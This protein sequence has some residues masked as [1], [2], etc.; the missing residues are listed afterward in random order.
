[1][2][3]RLLYLGS[4]FLLFLVLAFFSYTLEKE[5]LIT[6]ETG[7]MTR[8]L[9]HLEEQLKNNQAHY[10]TKII[11]DTQEY[12]LS[13]Y[14][15]DHLPI[16]T[17]HSSAP[18]WN[19]VTWLDK[20]TLYVHHEPS[21]YFLGV[22]SMVVSKKIETFPIIIR[23][24]ALFVPL[25]L[26]MALI[27]LVLSRI[28]FKPARNAFESVDTFIKHATHDLNTPIAAIL[29]NTRILEEKITEPSLHRFVRRITIG[30]KT[31]T[32]LY[33][34]LA[35][36][37]FQPHAP[38]PKPESIKELLQE[39]LS[40]LENLI[41]YKQL[42]VTTDLSDIKL[43]VHA[44]DFHRLLNNLLTNAIKYTAPKGLILL[45]MSLEYFSI[46]DSGI[47]LSEAE[48]QKIHER[49]WRGESFEAGLGIG[50]E[51]VVRVCKTYNL[52]LEIHSAKNQGS[53]FIIRWPKSLIA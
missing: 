31:L 10:L 48:K 33:E 6:D 41:E 39:Q 4:L 46:K 40:L 13:L 27:G 35:Y 12:R 16:A 5:R 37:N 52:T 38:I 30:A 53:E 45:T 14:D 36:L 47:G 15:I 50:M 32:G 49:Y 23:L 42:S 8:Y 20:S 28:A 19:D 2:Q 51:I 3:F 25:F 9:S 7:K 34:D 18:R 1:M 24:S 21:L 29:S 26:I 11:I 44:D 17:Q 43:T 22:A